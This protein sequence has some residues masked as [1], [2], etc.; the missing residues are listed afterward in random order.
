MKEKTLA[1]ENKKFMQVKTNEYKYKKKTRM[2]T[3]TTYLRTKRKNDNVYERK[4]YISMAET[5][6][7]TKE[8]VHADENIK[9]VCI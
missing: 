1:D 8:N 5:R 9:V 2:R 6:V 4:Q 7:Y 3:K